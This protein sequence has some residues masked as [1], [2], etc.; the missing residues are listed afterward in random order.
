MNTAIS[1]NKDVTLAQGYRVVFD[2]DVQGDNQGRFVI[3]TP[4]T[5]MWS[6]C[7][8][9]VIYWTYIDGKILFSNLQSVTILSHWQ[10][11]LG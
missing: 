2:K 7:T 10:Q 5:I 4:K 8:K 9:T 1:N 3:A 11:V 6:F